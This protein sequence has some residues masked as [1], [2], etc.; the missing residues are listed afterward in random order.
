MYGNSAETA[1]ADTLL[2]RNADASR[3]IQDAS[4][5]AD[6]AGTETRHQSAADANVLPDFCRQKRKQEKADPGNQDPPWVPDVS[7][8]L[9]LRPVQRGDIV[10]PFLR[11]VLYDEKDQSAVTR[12]RGC[13]APRSARQVCGI[14]TSWRPIGPALL[15]R[16]RPSCR[17]QMP[18]GISCRWRARRWRPPPGRRSSG[19]CRS[20]RRSWSPTS[21]SWS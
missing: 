19:G 4:L 20:R 10:P 16:S 14:P 13:P 11:R 7:Q 3:Q 12:L 15:C 5:M 6:Y 2:S 21:A 17:P 1:L 9:W 18:P 8:G